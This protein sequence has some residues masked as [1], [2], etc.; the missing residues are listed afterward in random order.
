MIRV[1]FF[2]LSV[3]WLMADE[4]LAVYLTCQRTPNSAMTLQWITPTRE[5]ASIKYCGSDG[6]WK[7]AKS[8]FFALP[9][10]M[11]YGVHRLELTDLQPDSEYRFQIE[12]SAKEY[13]F[14]TLPEQLKEPLQ[15]IVGG[16]I[17]NESAKLY[18]EMNIVAASQSPRFVLWGGDIA[19]AANR[20]F[21]LLENGKRW[22]DLLAIWSK[23]MITPQGHL[24][25][26]IA[27]IGNHDVTG[28]YDQTP[29]KAPYFYTLFPTPGYQ[30][31][32][33]GN[34]LSLFLLDSGHTHP[35]E[36]VQTEWLKNS[37]ASRK[38]VP[39]KFACYHVPA[40]PCARNFKNKYCE[41]V[42]K[43]WPPLFEEYGVLSA[44]EHHDHA[45]KRTYPISQG[46]KAQK[47]VLYIGDGG[48]GVE[49]LR[50]PKKSWYIANASSQRH[51]VS[52]TLTPQK[53]VQYKVINAARAI[54]D[55]FSQ[56]A[57]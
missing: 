47:G 39:F 30:T 14:L 46:K 18:E 44:F 38:N 9:N 17:F 6:I 50:R 32:D 27:V 19:Y 37:L 15:F 49:N 51:F 42:R 7:D 53:E 2:L 24:I 41:C 29:A 48:W 26:L 54:I 11:P 23:T 21:L 43:H 16:D 8:T 25:P 55:E 20:Y 52:V 36:G 56:N 33:F 40:F 31:L 34:Y 22:L 57:I 10:S 28:R 5:A 3:T 4:P 12:T 45:Y 35:V 13:K 1:I